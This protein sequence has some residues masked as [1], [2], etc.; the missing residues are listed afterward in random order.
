[1]IMIVIKRREQLMDAL[2]PTSASSGS[3]LDHRMKRNV[4]VHAIFDGGV[5]KIGNQ[6]LQD[7]DMAHTKSRNHLLLHVDND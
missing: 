1:M 4:N 2:T 7:T 6:Y 5:S 3:K